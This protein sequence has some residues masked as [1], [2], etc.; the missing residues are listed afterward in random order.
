MPIFFFLEIYPGARDLLLPC[1]YQW[2][3]NCIHGIHFFGTSHG[4]A[5]LQTCTSAQ[6][7][8]I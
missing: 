6:V 7:F 2:I 8:D 4:V 3:L 5:L 1:S